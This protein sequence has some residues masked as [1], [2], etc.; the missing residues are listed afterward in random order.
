MSLS[1]KAAAWW[2]SKKH[3]M[4]AINITNRR[5]CNC[6]T[7]LKYRSDLFDNAVERLLAHTKN[8]QPKIQIYVFSTKSVVT[9]TDS[10]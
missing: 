2:G 6:P 8:L 1:V 5:R 7:N 10:R 4:R 9:N 3:L